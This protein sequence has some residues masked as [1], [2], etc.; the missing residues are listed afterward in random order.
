MVSNE[1]EYVMYILVN[2]DLSMG[3]GKIVA[4]CCHSVT[5][6]IKTLEY[7]KLECYTNWLNNHE[8]KIVLKASEKELLYCIENYSNYNK[9][10]F[11]VHTI[12]LGRTQIKPNSL[13]TVVFCPIMRKYT[14]DLIR[15]LKLL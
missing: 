11:C 15:K 8:P 7:K 4:Q 3:K 6:M 1:N 13:T 9:D 5:R 12:D 2:Q 10:I 14:P